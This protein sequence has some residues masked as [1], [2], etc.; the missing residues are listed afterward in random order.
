MA[1]VAAAVGLLFSSRAF[2]IGA[3]LLLATGVGWYRRARQG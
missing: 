2:A 3:L 1:V